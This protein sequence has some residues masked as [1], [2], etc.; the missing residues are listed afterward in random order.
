MYAPI[1][2][3]EKPIT[4]CI[5]SLNIKPYNIAIDGFKDAF[6]T[7][8][9]RIVLSEIDEGDLQDQIKSANPD[10]ILSVGHSAL[11]RVREIRHTP[12]IYMM[13][14]N[15]V[16]S[17]SGNSNITGINLGYPEEKQ[18]SI[19][20]DL[21]PGIK[22]LMLIYN[23]ETKNTKIEHIRSELKEKEMRL[24][25]RPI[26][27]PKE[28]LSTLMNSGDNLGADVF[29]MIPDTT[30]INE[31]TSEAILLYALENKMPIVTFA[32]K[33]LDFGACIAITADEYDMG[34]QA[35][36]MAL[37]IFKETEKD[38]LDSLINIK[39]P[40]EYVEEPKIYINQKIIEK[41]EIIL[42]GDNGHRVSYI[43]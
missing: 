15:P 32:K 39:V 10:L 41:Y 16:G 34:K 6:P 12:I 2:N 5:Q 42:N 37:K 19:I 23:P 1:V 13:V 8:F 20:Q 30:V 29:L 4:L 43:N 24:I 22:S 27:S 9:K 18:V 28:V 14:C 21:L 7:R 26:Y 40:P 33:Y 38:G 36:R 3:A 25:A 35:A 17:L 31:V 11:M